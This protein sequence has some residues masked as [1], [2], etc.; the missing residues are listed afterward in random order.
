MEL[1]IVTKDGNLTTT[2]TVDLDAMYKMLSYDRPH[3]IYDAA[4]A[5][6]AMV[7]EV[8]FIPTMFLDALA[9][10]LEININMTELAEAGENKTTD[11]KELI[12][13]LKNLK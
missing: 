4:Q 10:Y 13:Q 5:V 3:P 12:E 8:G 9:Q 7:K 2:R 6:A 1:Q 11:Q